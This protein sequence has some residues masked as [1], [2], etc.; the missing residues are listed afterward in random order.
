[1]IE[2]RMVL[3]L[4]PWLH[5]SVQGLFFGLE[6]LKV[7]GIHSFENALNDYTERNTVS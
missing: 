3:T 4:C 6:H 5:L 7:F 1:L 2:K